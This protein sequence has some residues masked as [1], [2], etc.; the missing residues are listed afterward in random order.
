MEY[1][2]ITRDVKVNQAILHLDEENFA[3][4]AALVLERDEYPTFSVNTVWGRVRS[5]KRLAECTV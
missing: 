1:G 3:R 5:K 2:D 4:L